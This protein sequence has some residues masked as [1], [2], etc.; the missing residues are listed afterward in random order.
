[1]H[2]LRT[3]PAPSPSVV[4]AP[5]VGTMTRRMLGA[6]LALVLGVAGLSACTGDAKPDP[7]PTPTATEASA[8]VTDITD[9]PGSGEGLV[10]ALADTTVE[11]CEQGDGAWDVAG[12]VTNSS[13]AAA[14]YR[15]YVSLLTAGG[16]TRALS[17]VDVEPI[18]AGAETEWS[19]SI[20]LDEEDLSCVLRVERYAVEG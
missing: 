1:M 12:T 9:A 6:G 4:S 3:L 15:I 11:T 14:S 20:D 16:E 7:T 13:E 19:T 2:L 10:G 8:G 18:D 5:R 17:Q